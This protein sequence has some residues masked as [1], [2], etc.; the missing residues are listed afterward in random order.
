MG[1]RKVQLV[2]PRLQEPRDIRHRRQVVALETSVLPV[3]AVMSLC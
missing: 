2:Q 3:S 1:L